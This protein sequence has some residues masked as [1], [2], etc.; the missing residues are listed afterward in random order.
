MD[1]FTFIGLPT[2]RYS[3]NPCDGQNHVSSVTKLPANLDRVW[4]GMQSG[5]CC[6]RQ[7]L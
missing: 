3:R 4:D 2:Q 5:H 1:G 6:A 7:A